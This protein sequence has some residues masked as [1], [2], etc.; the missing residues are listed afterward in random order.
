MTKADPVFDSSDG[1]AFYFNHAYTYKGPDTFTVC[2]AVAHLKIVAAVR[3]DRV[4]VVQFHP[5][6][7]QRAGRALVERLIDGL[8]NA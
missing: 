4:V 7:S 5:E 8:C 3:R 1:E 6:K 2:H